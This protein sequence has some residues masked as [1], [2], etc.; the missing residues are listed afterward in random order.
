MR[1][2]KINGFFPTSGVVFY[3][4]PLP[5]WR[6]GSESRAYV[7]GLGQPCHPHPPPAKVTAELQVQHCRQ[8]G[9]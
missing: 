6:W 2:Q 5:L 9:T 1:K 7:Q 8:L 3:G 4:F